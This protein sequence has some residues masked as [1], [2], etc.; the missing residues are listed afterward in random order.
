M[1]LWRIAS[2]VT[3]C[4]STGG[5]TPPQLMKS[6][7]KPRTKKNLKLYPEPST[8]VDRPQTES[9]S[10]LP[11]MLRAFQQ[12]TGWSLQ[13]VGGVEPSQTG[14]LIWSTPVNPG[15]GAT[16]GHLRLDPV[17]P[18]KASTDQEPVDMGTARAMAS[19]LGGMLNELMEARHAVWQREAEL[20]AGVP[21]VPHCDE[22]KHLAE[23]LEAVLKGGAEAVGCHAAALYLLDEA[24]TE[25]KVR[26]RWGLPF[27]RLTAPAR[28][29]Q[30]E[31]ADLEALLGHAIVLE[32]TEVMRHWKV[33]EDFPAA[34]CLPVS[35]PT[36][37][38]GTVWFY[39]TEQRNF[40]DREVN[41]LEVVAGRL[42]ADL[43]RE[44]LMREGIS[45]AEVKR[46]LA[47]AERFQHNQLPSISPLLDG[48]ELAGWTAQSEA[49]GGDFHDWFC[50][51][52]GLLAVTVG[53]AMDR[54][55]EAAMAAV[56]MK[57]ALRAHG[58]YHREAEP[59]LKRLNL[60]MWTGSAGDQRAALFYGLIETATGRVC[61]AS[62]GGPSVA[63]VRADG[64]Q[65]LSRASA[66]MGESPQADCEQFVYQLQPGEAL[67]IFTDGFRDARDDRGRP[68]D[69]S[70]VIEPLVGLTDLSADQ[71]VT[72]AR[73]H[74]HRHAVSPDSADRTIL[75]IKRT[76]P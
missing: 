67:V 15:A 18:A 34:V 3:G 42:A 25:L 9:L 26:S 45:G 46:Q 44:M 39:C 8:K 19:A 58:Q 68:L 61:Y 29:L 22:E 11:G 41:I 53:H 14:S 71:L 50:L 10:S 7:A 69:E 30:G 62:A 74:L 76:N 17:D 75:V 72:V 28:P 27:D 35:T 66:P 59:A 24:T 65:S 33:P 63:V 38:L 60:T 47:A 64:W 54:G 1:K 36:T 40:N 49:V 16:P 20:A 32:D 48:W 23:R 37:L 4:K 57:A 55:I 2:P 31:L 21:L 12:A 51:P 13:Y 52:D 73:D 56:A 5:L 6:V 43:E 70:G